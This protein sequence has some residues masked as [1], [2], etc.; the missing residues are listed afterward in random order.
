MVDSL[1]IKDVHIINK[2]TS[3]GTFTKDKGT[4]EIPVSLGDILYI[5]HINYS[6]KEIIITRENIASKK[7]IISINDKTYALEEVILKKKVSPFYLDPQIIPTSRITQVQLKL[8]YANVKPIEDKST[9]RAESGV[10]INIVSFIN[11]INGKRKKERE[12]KKAK[13]SDQRIDRLRAKFSNSF[14]HHHLKIKKGYI[15]Q[16]LEYS[17]ARG[18]FQLPEKENIIQLTDFLIQTSKTFTHQK[19]NHDTLLTKK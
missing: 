3:K 2:T 14:F 4:F 8:P 12:L 1:G 19:I 15:N 9:L 16:F 7:I 18:V 5:S 11:S 10:A 17:V 13:L 6:K